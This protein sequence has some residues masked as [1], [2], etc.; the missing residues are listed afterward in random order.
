MVSSVP[1]S[2]T[3]GGE[4]AGASVCGSTA[5]SSFTGKVISTAECTHRLPCP[6]KCAQ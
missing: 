2:S 4:E 5:H 3:T 6:M 1:Q